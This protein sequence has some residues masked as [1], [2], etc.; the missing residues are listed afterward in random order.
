MSQFSLEELFEIKRAERPPAEFWDRFEVELKRRQLKAFVGNGVPAEPSAG[1]KWFSSLA[2]SAFALSVPLAFGLFTFFIWSG[3]PTVST[4]PSAG[5]AQSVPESLEQLVMSPVELAS[6][7]EDFA[8]TSGE[9]SEYLLASAQNDFVVDALSIPT[10]HQRRESLA[11]YRDLSPRAYFS[12]VS[13][14][15]GEY[16][17]DLVML[18]TDSLSARTP[19]LTRFTY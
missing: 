4:D 12:Q 14:S 3:S 6:A 7:P 2:T 1:R 11:F 18:S 8:T 16:V 15:A 10:D 19:A 5:F 13:Q 9:L 17:A